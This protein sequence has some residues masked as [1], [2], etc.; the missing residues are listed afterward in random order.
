M[1]IAL[2]RQRPAIGDA[3]LLGPLIRAV[4]SRYPQSTLTVVTDDEYAAGA[5]PIIFRGLPEVD[6]VASV[7][8][9]AW[10]TDSNRDVDD[11]VRHAGRIAPSCV[12]NS[13]LMLDCNGAFIQYERD[14]SGHPPW[15][16][17][18]FWVRHHGFYKDGMDLRPTYVPSEDARLDAF[19]RIE[20]L[21]KP[22]PEMVGIV[23]RAGD[24]V[25]DWD[26]DG[27]STR[28]AEYVYHLGFSP[29]GIDRDHDLLSEHACTFRDAPI[30]VVAA[31]LECCRL[32]IAPDTGLLHLAEA[33]GTPTVALWGIMDPK[34]R[35]DGYNC[36]VVPEESLGY[37]RGQEEDD[38]PCWKFQRY[39]CLR[40][41]SIS[42][43]AAGIVKQ[44]GL[45][46]E[47]VPLTARDLSACEAH[48]EGRQES[49]VNLHRLD[50]N[51]EARLFRTAH[52]GGT[53]VEY[54]GL[55]AA[56]VGVFAPTRVIITGT[57]NADVVE[58]VL[59]RLSSGS[60]VCLL[61]D[62]SLSR[63]RVDK[64]NSLAAGTGAVFTCLPLD[65]VDFGGANMGDEVSNIAGQGFHF[66]FLDSRISSVALEFSC[67]TDPASNLL[68]FMRPLC[69]CIHDMSRYRHPHDSDTGELAAA[70]RHIEIVAGNR[71][72]QWIRLNQSRGMIVLV[73]YPKSRSAQIHTDPF[74][75]G[76]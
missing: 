11:N 3:L 21:D 75:S 56:L 65:T 57:W 63:R 70:I 10:T 28:V 73:K 61:T 16:I 76:T 69:I 35:V 53:E 9:H 60:T 41:M 52:G 48:G 54:Q 5:L 25:R 4:K 6:R 37:C 55:L 58:V 38:C 33:V 40:R 29:V 31:L 72:W 62:G 45:K 46:E 66:A 36:A 50:V 15:G 39:S 32:V 67:L 64:L 7:S 74:A 51:P 23:L 47:E 43:V 34:L 24:P 1:N 44:L 68:D 26:Y 42:H 8:M 18:E 59:E 27:L 2:V 71:G 30:D 19:N 22:F 20:K 17:A 13:D 14:C 49:L 12:R